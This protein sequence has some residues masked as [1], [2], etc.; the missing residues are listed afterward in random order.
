MKPGR[1]NSS[2]EL[3]AALDRWEAP[4]RELSRPVNDDFRLL[5]LR[6]LV[7]KR[8]PRAHGDAGISMELSGAFSSHDARR[9]TCATCVRYNR[10]N[11]RSRD[12]PPMGLS[13]LCPGLAA[14][15]GGEQQPQTGG[16]CQHHHHEPEHASEGSDLD[17]VIA[18]LKRQR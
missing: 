3:G 4:E 12:K 2:Q 13:S 6:E 5:A 7:P 18:A 1:C 9:Q 8:V 11:A 15:G 16:Q 14:L 17:K 10:C